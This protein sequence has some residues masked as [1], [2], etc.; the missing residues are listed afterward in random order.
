VVESRPPLKR[1]TAGGP[2][3]AARAPLVMRGC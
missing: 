1:I 2:S 3:P